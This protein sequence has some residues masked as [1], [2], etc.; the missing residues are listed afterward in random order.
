L[1]ELAALPTDFFG[2]GGHFLL[3][4]FAG[5]EASVMD[6]SESFIS[7][8]F[9][10]S[11][12]ASGRGA[13]EALR[14]GHGEMDAGRLHYARIFSPMTDALRA[15]LQQ[16]VDVGHFPRGGDGFTVTATNGP[17]P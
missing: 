15:D 14:S 1:G 10:D 13:I 5:L 7:Q 9:L 16:K 2:L 17:R 4:A 11:V 8:R 12:F 6:C 3:G